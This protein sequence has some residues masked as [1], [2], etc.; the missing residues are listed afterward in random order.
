MA[1]AVPK[2]KQSRQKPLPPA[3]PF[4]TSPTTPFKHDEQVAVVLGAGAT[5]A[6]DGPLTVEILSKAFE[7]TKG[8]QLDLLDKF[9]Q[10]IFSVPAGLK[11]RKPNDYPPLPTV[12][13]LLD[14]AISREHDF[15]PDWPTSTLRGVRRQT[16]YAVF[17]AIAHSMRKSSSWANRCHEDLIGTIHARTGRWPSVV[18][19]NY[20]LRADYAMI[21]TDGGGLPD[22]G[23]DIRNPEYQKAAKTGRLFKIH[24]S[25][26]W[27]YCPTCH[28]LE[29]GLDRQ[30]RLRK[31]GLSLAWSLAHDF[32]DGL[33]EKG[34]YC[35]DCKTRFRTVMITPTSLK[36]YRNPHIASLWYQAERALRQCHRVVFVGYSL[37]WDDVDVIY[38]LKRGLSH[39]SRERVTVVEWA[40]QPV[41][42]DSHEAGQRYQ[43]VFGRGLD[44]QP[45]G[46]VEWV[47]T[48]R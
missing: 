6:C 28:R 30:G 25:M 46:F 1:T 15:G 23:C 3:R 19:L 16:E 31:A 40:P 41:P 45:S 44:W 17:K 20:D 43:A 13:S 34:I 4:K 18:S 38:L 35:P 48:L 12:L 7:A 24:G 22:Y 36:D 9:L 2:S 21:E 39:L 42:I 14:T 29:M 47:K 10:Q 26:H 5:K 8:E 11:S 37:P 32:V 27:L 33:S